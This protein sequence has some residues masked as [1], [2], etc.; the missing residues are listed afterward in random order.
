MTTDEKRGKLEDILEEID[1]AGCNF[2]SEVHP[3]VIDYPPYTEEEFRDSLEKTIDE[4][5]WLNETLDTQLK[6]LKVL[7]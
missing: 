7:R 2:D 5:E 1:N 6:A 3:F 4:L